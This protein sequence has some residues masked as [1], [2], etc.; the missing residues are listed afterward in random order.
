MLLK[1]HDIIKSPFCRFHFVHPRIPEIK[2]SREFISELQKTDFKSLSSSRINFPERVMQSTTES[3]DHS[4]AA[5]EEGLL[6]ISTVDAN[7]SVK[8]ASTDNS[9]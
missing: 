9:F 3:S 2:K 8:T 4:L 1:Y 6:L 7:L 5:W